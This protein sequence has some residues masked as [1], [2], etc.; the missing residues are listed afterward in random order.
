MM[1]TLLLHPLR[2]TAAAA[3]LL[4]LGA[5]ASSPPSS[6]YTL[7]PLPASDGAG[8]DLRAGGL[9]L[10]IGPVT[11][12]QFLDRPQIVARDSANRL[13][14]NEFH[15]WGGTVQDDFLRVWGENLG[16]LLGTSRVLAAPSE[17]RIPLDFRI[18]AEVLAF[19]GT[20]GNEA[21]LKVRWSVLDP[22]LERTLASREDAYRC[23][24]KAPPPTQGTVQVLSG[25]APD[26]NYQAVVAALSQCL[27]DFSQDVAE[28]VRT[29]PRPIPDDG[30][31]AR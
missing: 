31:R 30:A 22:Y 13:S 26:Q 29:L 4:L 2:P 28:V 27:G 8:A 15:R 5:C 23:P 20:P 11:F 25:K 12:P 9:A 14:L 24:I 10:G 21:L 17:V 6:F 16:Y 7:S 1:Q 19:E 3:L 18:A